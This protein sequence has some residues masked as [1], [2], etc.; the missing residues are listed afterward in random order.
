M[1]RTSPVAI[2]RLSP[3]DSLRGIAAIGVAI[4][5]HY[6]HFNMKLFEAEPSQLP[7][8]SQF[9]WFYLCG[10][11]LVD[12][13]F[14]LSGFIFMY[15]YSEK[16]VSRK[17]GE[18]S[19]F[20]NRI[21]RLYPLHIL[22]LVIVAVV[23]YSRL[24]SNHSFFIF[25]NN[26]LYHLFLNVFFLQA[27]L[28]ND[29]PSFNAASWS[30][31][32]E[33]AAYILFFYILSRYKKYA[34]AFALLVFTG[35][36]ISH[37]RL[38]IPIFNPEMARMLTGF[39]T[40]CLLYNIQTRIRQFSNIGRIMLLASLALFAAAVSLLVIKAGYGK[41]FG[42][43]ERVMPLVV[44]PLI[45]IAVLNSSLL[46]KIFSLRPFTFFGDISYSV[47]LVHFPFQL[48]MVTIIELAGFSPD[49]RKPYML[50]L[51]AAGTILFSAISYYLFEKP[52][53]ERIRKKYI[54]Q[55]I[56]REIRTAA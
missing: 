48:V 36:S 55:S 7:F 10:W 28:F 46:S 43:W 3:L 31:S 9:K 53:Q 32:C 45:I 44:Y 19:F 37:T 4:F 23:Q 2:Q 35:I 50:I 54:R 14:V 20:I 40:G 39:F 1:N 27:G 22:T 26:D 6:R 5:W 24:L 38:N 21:S 47:Y 33:M 11:N 13:F 52:M 56:N 42:H 17:I 25:Q 8:Y 29:G 49:Y 41:I 34:A 51:Y 18:Q 15:V 12:F 30:L 16:I